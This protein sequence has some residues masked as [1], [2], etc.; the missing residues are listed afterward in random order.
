[1]KNSIMVK[2]ILILSLILSGLGLNA[3]EKTIDEW[4][5]PR[6]ARDFISKNFSEQKIV[7]LTRDDKRNDKEYEAVLN[8]AVKIEFDR[9]GYWKEVDGNDNAIPTQFIPS[10]IMGYITEN[11]PSGKIEKIEKNR[12]RYKVELLN[13]LELKFDSKGKFL[14]LDD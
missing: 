1:M 12:N 13:G 10:K 14:K 7:R 6:T 4:E 5:L 8:N 11:Y 3:Q 2:M 9:L